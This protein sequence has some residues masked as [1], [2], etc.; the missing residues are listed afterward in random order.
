MVVSFRVLLS[1]TRVYRPTFYTFTSI[2]MIAMY[3]DE[4]T[5]NIPIFHRFFVE[6]IGLSTLNTLHAWVGT[7]IKMLRPVGKN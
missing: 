6:G 2:P 1:S 4:R 3:L 7:E 5:A